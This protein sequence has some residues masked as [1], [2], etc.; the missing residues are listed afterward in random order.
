MSERRLLILGTGGFAE[1]AADLAADIPGVAVT[2]FVESLERSRCAE[3]RIG[4]PIIW[5]DDV[6]RFAERHVGVCA[7]GTTKRAPFIEQA[8]R[9]G[10]RY[11]Q[12][13]HPLARLSRT[14]DIG[15]GAILSVGA[16]VATQARL[17]RHVIV[18]RA[19]SIGHHT[20]V[21]DFV[22]IGPGAHICGHCRIGARTFVAVG[23]V[24]ADH[25]TVGAG[26][27]IA[28]GA[29]VT[30]D[31]PDHVVVAGVPARIIKHGADGH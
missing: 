20:E 4:L 17:G 16:I 5:I 25:V 29:V 28:A 10:L 27:V 6:A 22:T 13:V 9:L 1:E 8:A 21:G 12:L 24:V 23:A 19:A 7:V 18:N 2:G 3:T 11:T 14:A 31:V 30:G 15:E 26:T